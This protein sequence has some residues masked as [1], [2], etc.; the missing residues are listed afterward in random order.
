MIRRVH[1]PPNPWRDGEIDWLE[2]PPKARLEVFLDHSKSILSR[3]DSPDLSFRWSINPYR[4]CFHAC[5]YCY[6]RPSHQHLD[7]GA[8]TDFDRK[9]VVK[10]DA[11]ALLEAELNRDRWKGEL[12]AFSGNTDCY[13]PI[14]SSFHLTRKCLE[15]CARYRNPVGVI[16]KSPLIERDIDLLI[17]MVCES[18][19]RV[20]VS[21]AFSD[22]ATAKAI[23]PNVASPRRRL[24]TI[25][26]LTDAGIPVGILVAPVIPGLNDNQI[27]EILEQAREAGARS[28]GMLLLRLPETVEE[29]FEA[30]L[31][32]SLPLRA[33][34]VLHQL[35]ACRGGKRH[36]PAFGKR[37]VGSGARWRAI[38]QLFERT[39]QRL[40]FEGHEPLPERSPFRRR[41]QPE[42]LAL[43]A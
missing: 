38:E 35:E 18:Y 13:Q 37:M 43:F 3:N 5:A 12:I 20:S 26:R 27:P 7:F 42:Q 24:Q 4:G 15:V 36:T 25:R 9:I 31:R 10:P 23:E 40:G 28:A 32:E 29:V 34:R 14:E 41:S 17:E 6:A 30:R 11:A 8:G 2:E 39:V 19:C 16:T 21:L 33:D 22:A 1:N